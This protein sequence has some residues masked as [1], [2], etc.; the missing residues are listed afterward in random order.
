MYDLFELNEEYALVETL[1]RGDLRHVH[2]FVL[3]GVLALQFLDSN[4]LLRLFVNALDDGSVCSLAQLLYK[5]VL[6]HYFYYN[7]IL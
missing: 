3:G 5:L 6:I 2:A 4:Q 1:Q 7:Y